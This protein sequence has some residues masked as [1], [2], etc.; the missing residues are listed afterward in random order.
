MKAPSDDGRYETPWKCIECGASVSRFLKCTRIRSPTRACRSGP[1]MPL[2]TTSTPS[3]L[4]S[5]CF[6]CGV[7]RRYA[8]V[9]TIVCAASN[10]SPMMASRPLGT[11]F[12]VSGIAPT[13]YSRTAAPAVD[14]T[15]SALRATSAPSATRRRW[16]IVP[17]LDG[18]RPLHPGVDR[19]DEVQRRAGLGADLGRRGLLRLQNDRVAGLIDA[20][21]AH[22]DDGLLRRRVAVGVG[23]VL[24]ADRLADLAL[25]DRAG[26]LGHLRALDDREGVRS[27]VAG[28]LDRQRP[29]R[30]DRQV[31]DDPV[32]RVLDVLVDLDLGPGLG[33]LGGRGGSSLTDGDGSDA[34]GRDERNGD[35]QRETTSHRWFPFWTDSGG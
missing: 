2:S 6:Q 18:E 28:R 1:W 10:C 14:G 13:Q 5:A 21:G 3:A 25:E 23:A 8:T 4:G 35:E 26:R 11:T 20:R 15:A 16:D 7:K 12:H 27:R 33:G 19:A 31:R 32:R 34:D 9:C 17:L 29:A 22:V 30:G 24:L